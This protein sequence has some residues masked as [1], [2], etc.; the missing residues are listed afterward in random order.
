MVLKGVHLKR[1][2]HGELNGLKRSQFCTAYKHMVFKGV[3]LIVIYNG[4]Q[5]TQFLMISPYS[6]V[7]VLKEANFVGMYIGLEISQFA[8]ISKIPL[9]GLERTKLLPYRQWS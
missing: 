7:M 1:V 2:S 8:L 3:N 5:R 4:L 9:N 6:T